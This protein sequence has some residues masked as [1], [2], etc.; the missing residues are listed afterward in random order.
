M[1]A[2]GL[3]CLGVTFLTELTSNTA[4]TQILLPLL[5]AGAARAGADPVIWMLPATISA[6][7]AFMMPVA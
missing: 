5:A 4:T 3:I 1:V 6:S 7:C 2:V